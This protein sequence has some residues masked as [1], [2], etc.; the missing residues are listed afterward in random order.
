M[1]DS[2]IFRLVGGGTRTSLKTTVGLHFS[3]ICLP[4]MAPTSQTPPA[5]VQHPACAHRASQF[6]CM[7]QTHVR[8]LNGAANW[9]TCPGENRVIQASVE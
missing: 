6:T 4:L 3:G 1:P 9:S 5:M 7:F 8:H 2:S